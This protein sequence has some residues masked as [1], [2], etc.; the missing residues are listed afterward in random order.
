[1]TSA[2]TCSSY[3]MDLQYFT[4][5]RH[6]LAL[7]IEDR[8]QLTRTFLYGALSIINVETS[9]QW[10]RPPTLV[11]SIPSECKVCQDVFIKSIQHFEWI[12]PLCIRHSTW[13]K[14]ASI[15][16]GI[17]S[18]VLPRALEVNIVYIRS[19]KLDGIGFTFSTAFSA[20]SARLPPLSD[21]RTHISILELG[22]HKSR[23]RIF[24][25]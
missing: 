11:W 13:V 16:S 21:D 22:S 23:S 2:H 15:T 6:L 25:L 7:C 18:I 14:P 19:M 4:M 5:L 9:H 20:S 1:M 24:S 8:G 10:I 17:L 3:Q 12:M